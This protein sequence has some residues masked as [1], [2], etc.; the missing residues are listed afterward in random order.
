[1]RNTDSIGNIRPALIDR[2]ADVLSAIRKFQPCYRMFRIAGNTPTLVT[3]V[4]KVAP[5]M[6]AFVHTALKTLA[7]RVAFFACGVFSVLIGRAYNDLLAFD[8]AR[9]QAWIVFSITIV[10]VGIAGVS[11]AMLPESWAKI[12]F[13]KRMDHGAWLSLPV[14]LLAAF[15]VMAY[16]VVAVPALF[17]PTARL[18]PLL[19]YVLCPSCVL[20]VTVDPSLASSLLVL[21]P[22][23]AAVYGSIGGAIGVLIRAT[24]K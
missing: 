14:K 5:D 9:R 20:T 6:L 22:M 4:L 19:V 3:Q 23:S 18:S 17:S 21:A 1:M 8:P 15:F 13:G 7:Y 16:A 10:A 11:I 2:E 24:H 12:L